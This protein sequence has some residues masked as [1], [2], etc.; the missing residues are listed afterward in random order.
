ML[1]GECFRKGNV[2]YFEIK[3]CGVW[4][5]F[6][7]SK[8]ALLLTVFE[9]TFLFIFLKRRNVKKKVL[10][11]VP[12]LNE[13]GLRISLLPLISTCTF[14]FLVIH[15][16]IQRYERLKIKFQSINV[17]FSI[18]LSIEIKNGPLNY[19]K[20]FLLAKGIFPFLQPFPFFF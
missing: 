15:L 18:I 9:L 13:A 16:H 14:Y 17:D 1:R 3:T 11:V 2:S 10:A 8:V 5:I 6:E 19:G 7:Q 12:V 20:K 4:T